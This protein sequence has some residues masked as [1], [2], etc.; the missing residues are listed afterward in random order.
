VC[1][2]TPTQKQLRVYMRLLRRI[3]SIEHL[4]A[5]FFVGKKILAWEGKAFFF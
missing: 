5:V 3:R 4:M 2:R 1:T